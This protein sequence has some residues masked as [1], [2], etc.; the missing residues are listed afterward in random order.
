ML[1]QRKARP[2]K[3]QAP[4]EQQ[5][6]QI[7]EFCRQFLRKNVGLPYEPADPIYVDIPAEKFPRDELQSVYRCTSW[8]GKWMSSAPLIIYIGVDKRVELKAQT[9]QSWADVVKGC[10]DCFGGNSAQKLPV[11]HLHQGKVVAFHGYTK[12]CFIPSAV[13]HRRVVR[14]DCHMFPPG[15]RPYELME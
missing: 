1:R 9:Y 13:K 8:W 3:G 2:S 14:V 15:E 6:R 10:C 4:D 11:Q 7:L 12:H 5:R